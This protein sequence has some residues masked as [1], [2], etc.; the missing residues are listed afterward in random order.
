MSKDS[1]PSGISATPFVATDE[2]RDSPKK[3]FLTFPDPPMSVFCGGNYV[4]DES[5]TDDPKT[6]LLV[7]TIVYKSIQALERRLD[8]QL[9][10][11][12]LSCRVDYR[13]QLMERRVKSLE[14]AMEHWRVSRIPC[15]SSWCPC[16]KTLALHTQ[17]LG[18][19]PLL[20]CVPGLW[21]REAHSG[22]C[23]SSSRHRAM[24][25]STS[26]GC[27]KVSWRKANAA[28]TSVA[29]ATY[30]L[31]CCATQGWGEA[32]TTWTNHG[33]TQPRHSLTKDIL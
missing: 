21:A 15:M 23:H 26:P 25:G 3:C 6:K 8:R 2:D 9:D 27:S 5:E 22:S 28:L 29:S 31:P 33:R 16:R 19:Q 20:Q 13:F 1:K 14:H 12:P 17:Q 7:Q 18:A 32:A 30:Y 10:D 4:E 24:E 11:F